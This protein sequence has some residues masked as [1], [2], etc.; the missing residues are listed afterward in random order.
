MT[1]NTLQG[2]VAF[3]L[4]TADGNSTAAIVKNNHKAVDIQVVSRTASEDDQPLE[5]EPSPWRREQ[6]ELQ[7]C[8]LLAGSV[9]RDLELSEKLVD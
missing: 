7:R 4:A 5:S 3:T 1:T 6:H 2:H 8:R 9:R